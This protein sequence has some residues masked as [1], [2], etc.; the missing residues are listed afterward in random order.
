MMRLNISRK[1][2]LLAPAI[3]FVGCATAYQRL[4]E[5]SLPLYQK[6]TPV[7]S[8]IRV[9]CR[10]V[11]VSEAGRF[12]VSY[13]LLWDLTDYPTTPDPIRYETSW[14]TNGVQVFHQTEQNKNYKYENSSLDGGNKDPQKGAVNT[15]QMAR[16]NM[17]GL[18]ARSTLIQ[19]GSAVVEG[20]RYPLGGGVD[21][22]GLPYYDVVPY[23]P[24]SIF[25][26]NGLQWHKKT[27][28]EIFL[29]S[30]NSRREP[31]ELMEVYQA[32]VGNYS[33]L[34]YGKF[35]KP[36]VEHPDW[37]A[38]RRAFLRQWVETFKVEPIKP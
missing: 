12:Q 25:V 17:D 36:I 9:V 28:R 13:D 14:C 32:K 19:F 38:E 24:E 20:E 5:A 26:A 21:A 23:E 22:F 7:M 6:G 2:I 34:V 29:G 16:T 33:V 10:R 35:T 15:W 3:L 4:E 30:D 37:L 27:W 31:G 1:L 8:T 11:S 18:N